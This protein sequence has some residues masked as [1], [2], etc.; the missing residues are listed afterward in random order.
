MSIQTVRCLVTGI[1][2]LEV[3]IIFFTFTMVRSL[4]RNA[5]KSPLLGM[6]SLYLMMLNLIVQKYYI[7]TILWL[8]IKLKLLLLLL[9]LLLRVS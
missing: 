4:T 8:M 5:C 3:Q 6:H 9:I 2:F 7:D 1:H